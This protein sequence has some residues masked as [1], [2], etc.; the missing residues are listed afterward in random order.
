MEA[1]YKIRVKI[2]EAEFQAE[3]N[4]Q[5]INPQFERF[6]N[7]LQHATARSVAES[8]RKPEAQNDTTKRPAITEEMLARVFVSDESG[9][10]SLHALPPKGEGETHEADALV[11]I[12]YGFRRL[13]DHGTVMVDQLIKAARQSG[14]DPGGRVSRILDQRRDMI[15]RSGTRRGTKYGLNNRGT[16]HAESLMTTI[17][18]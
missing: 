11:L 5:T 13:R 16:A 3:G 8:I 17:L 10:V 7:F 1:T 4:Q 18:D 15:T 12:L 2:G 6:L 14:I 9:L